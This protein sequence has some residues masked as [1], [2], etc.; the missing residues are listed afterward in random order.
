MDWAPTRPATTTSARI[1]ICFRVTTHLGKPSSGLFLYSCSDK[2]FRQW[3]YTKGRVPWGTLPLCE[4]TT[5][6]TSQPV[7]ALGRPNVDRLLDLDPGHFLARLV[8]AQH[9][10]VVHLEALP[11]DLG[12]K[13]LRARNDV[14]PEDDLLT[15]APELQH[16]QQFPARHEI[17]LDG[18]IDP[19]PKH[20][21]GIA[22][23]AVPRRNVEAVGLGAPLR[24]QRERHLLHPNRVVQGVPPIFGPQPVVADAH[25]ALH[26]DL[27]HT[28]RHTARFHRLAPRQGVFAFNARITRDALLADARRAAVHRLLKRA[29]FHALLVPAATVLVDQYD[30]VFGP[31]VDGFARTGCQAARVG[32]VVTDPLEI[33][34]ERFMLR[35]T[36]AR[37]A[38]RLLLAEAR[39][40]DPFDQGPHRG[41]R[42]FINIDEPPLL[43][44]RD[45]P[46]RR[47]ADLD[48]RVEN[49]HPLK[50]PIGRMVLAAHPHVPHLPPR[51][52]LLDELGDLHVVEL[53]IPPVGLGLHVVPPHVFLA[54]RK[55]PG[56][57]VRHRTGLTRQTPIDVEHKGKLPLRMPLLIG[58]Q[59]L[60]SQ[61]PVID[62]WHC[63][64]SFS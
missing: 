52:H 56:R 24:I 27:P 64:S 14:V 37:Q 35:Q 4:A 48:P 46:N 25:Q 13:H 53:R 43:V 40:V 31:L 3:P 49:G 19:R 44:R 10:V 58:I 47:L 26:A 6:Y 29:L 28:G 7:D 1:T 12:L 2:D 32:A 18:T 22:P 15:G 45:I 33:E 63:V 41:R 36:A 60:P 51:V 21:P 42:V 39:L 20:L 50:H 17:L 23:G 30:A 54:L 57:L 38:P 11:V 5:S 62:F 55:Q 61:L 16:R 34:K 59:H 9:G 8:E